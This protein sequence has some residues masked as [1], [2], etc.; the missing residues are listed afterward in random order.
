VLLRGGN[1]RPVTRFE[2][3]FSLP[4]GSEGKYSVGIAVSFDG[5]EY[6][7][8]KTLPAAIIRDSG[9][10]PDPPNEVV[11]P[12]PLPPV[13]TPTP[14]PVPPP[15][16]PEPVVPAAIQVQPQDAVVAVGQQQRFYAV[17]VDASGQ[18]IQ[19][20]AVT[21]SLEG[22]QDVG[23]ISSNGIFVG[24]KAG[25]VTVVAKVGAVQG[26]TNVRVTAPA[27][28]PGVAA[29][30]Q[31]PGTEGQI[32]LGLAGSAAGGLK[33]IYMAGPGGVFRSVNDG[34]FEKIAPGIDEGYFP[35][36]VDANPADPRIVFVG[37]LNAG[38]YVS[39]DAGGEW[40]LYSEEL[41][42]PLMFFFSGEGH[43]PIVSV[44]TDAE[45]AVII[46]TAGKGTFVRLDPSGEW[47]DVSEGLGTATVNSFVMNKDATA[48][49]LGTSV[50]AYRLREGET[51][52][53]PI[54]NGLESPRSEA[55][56]YSMLPFV[57][58][59]ALNPLRETELLAATDE[60]GVFF[61]SN[62]GDTWVRANSGITTNKIYAVAFDPKVPGRMFAGTADSGVF[63][64]TDGGKSWQAARSGLANGTITALFF[65]PAN[66]SRLYAGTMGDGVW[67]LDLTGNIRSEPP[68]VTYTTPISGEKD[69][70]PTTVETAA[71]ATAMDAASINTSTFVVKDASGR[72]VAGKVTYDAVHF[73]A[74]F[75]P[76]APLAG[77]TT[78]TASITTGARDAAG[79]PLQQEYTWSFTTAKEAVTPPPAA[80][81][82]GDV[83]GDGKV[84]IVDATMALRIAVG[85]IQPTQAQLS[86]GDLNG[87]GRIAINEV[88]LIL[89]AA[90]GL[91]TL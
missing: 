20:A 19:N 69:V 42:D 33:I 12:T 7:L 58:R 39:E 4:E 1:Q 86:A 57:N 54:N 84:N 80:V 76:S 21:W 90:V 55:D 81:V 32:V 40:F 66:P 13:P 18:T 53:K 82:R 30:K 17:V 74:A 50:G 75:T 77:G 56:R 14:E 79:T 3:V 43:P 27:A 89:R 35:T 64:S 49:F 5:R 51:A 61:S 26:R 28:P 78:Y 8:A 41:A 62:E 48:M 29:W 36:C 16:P 71:F 6:N 67:Y 31:L 83:T 15:V 10:A 88:L 37:T 60:D 23:E 73:V 34:R 59:I 72:L 44:M 9:P 87:D 45:N 2:F 25:Q 52:W 91:G 70:S 11:S 65:D 22:P 46:G 63:V 68:R 24:R 47:L 38:L 85:I